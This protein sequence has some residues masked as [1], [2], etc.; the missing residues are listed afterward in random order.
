VAVAQSSSND[1]AVCFFCGG[2]H[3]YT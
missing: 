2:H 3:L 1:N